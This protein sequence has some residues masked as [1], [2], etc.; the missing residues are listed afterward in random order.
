MH[1]CCYI[2]LCARLLL[3]VFFLMRRV[4]LYSLSPAMFSMLKPHRGVLHSRAFV[5]ECYPFFWDL[6]YISL[7]PVCACRWDLPAA[8]C[9]L[10][11]LPGQLEGF[12]L[13]SHFRFN[14]TFLILVR[15]SIIIA[16]ILPFKM[17]SIS[18]YVIYCYVIYYPL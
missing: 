12:T 7:P 17:P 13:I 5:T 1:G 9:A 6:C 14:Q 18:R 10:S 11:V 3:T 15:P 16:S 4:S 2:F 8:F